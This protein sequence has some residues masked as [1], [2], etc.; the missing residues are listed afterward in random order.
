M[1]P[2]GEAKRATMEGF[3]R[4]PVDGPDLGIWTTCPDRSFSDVV[5]EVGPLHSPSEELLRVR[6]PAAPILYG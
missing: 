5:T 3:G 4:L 6:A 2:S 1:R